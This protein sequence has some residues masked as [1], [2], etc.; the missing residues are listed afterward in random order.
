MANVKKKQTVRPSVRIGHNPLG[1]VT[2]RGNG[3]GPR[4]V[5]R[6]HTRQH[7]AANVVRVG[8]A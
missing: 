2:S 5:R 7:A 8:L 6:H 4:R 3:T 1:R